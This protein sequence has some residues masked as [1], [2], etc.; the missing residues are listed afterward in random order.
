MAANF[1]KAYHNSLFIKAETHD[2]G[3]GVGSSNLLAPTDFKSRNS[4]NFDGLRFFLWSTIPL[5][6]LVCDT[7]KS[8]KLN[9]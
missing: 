4:M 9:R 1:I 7:D 3:K 5:G 6:D 2:W 8:R